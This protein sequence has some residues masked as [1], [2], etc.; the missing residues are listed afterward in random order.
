MQDVEQLVGPSDANRV[1][2]RGLCFGSIVVPQEAS[3]TSH[4]EHQ[5]S[6]GLA[7]QRTPLSGPCHAERGIGRSPLQSNEQPPSHHGELQPQMAPDTEL[8]W[9]LP[10]CDVT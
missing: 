9:R 2:F 4:R 8:M 6:K 3:G 1:N 7:I 10:E 5:L